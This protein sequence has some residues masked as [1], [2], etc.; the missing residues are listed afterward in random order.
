M[1][2]TNS[3]CIFAWG[4]SNEFFEAVSFKWG[5]VLPARERGILANFSNPDPVDVCSE[6][7]WKL[8]VEWDENAK[9]QPFVRWVGSF[10]RT[11]LVRK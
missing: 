4:G 9:L 6:A 2:M 7:E 1:G 11:R 8:I 10:S 3:I 5:T